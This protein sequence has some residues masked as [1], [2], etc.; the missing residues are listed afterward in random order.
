[1][2]GLLPA[3]GAHRVCLAGVWSVWCLRRITQLRGQWIPHKRRVFPFLEKSWKARGEGH[4][5]APFPLLTGSQSGDWG[6]ETASDLFQVHE[7]GVCGHPM[8]T[9]KK[10]NREMES[11]RKECGEGEAE[12]M[13]CRHCAP[14]HQHPETK[15]TTSTELGLA[16]SWR[17]AALQGLTCPGCTQP[18]GKS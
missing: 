1:M 11:K 7:A 13:G 6:P 16:A 18:A 4:V 17:K 12:T 9:N 2:A 8:S 10:P 14:S 3:S 15:E 5:P